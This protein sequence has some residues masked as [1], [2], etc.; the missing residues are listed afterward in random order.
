MR[1]EDFKDIEEDFQITFKERLRDYM[2]IFNLGDDH[3]IIAMHMGGVFLEC[4]LKHKII[5]MY[6]LKKC[7]YVKK[8]EVWF[9]DEAVREIVTEDKPTEQYIKSRGIINPGHNL[10][11]AIK[12]LRDLDESLNSYDMELVNNP[13][14]NDSK[15][16]KSFIDL[17]YC[18]I[19]DFRNLENTFDSWIKSFNNLKSIIVAYKGW[20][21]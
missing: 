7:K 16:Y 21:E 20:E 13:L 14:I 6:E 18:T 8:N 11:N 4:L 15:E 3:R 9:S 5:S 17:E 19:K 2:R 10:I 1:L 12:L